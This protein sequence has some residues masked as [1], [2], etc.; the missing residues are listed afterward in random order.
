MPNT[1]EVKGE[2]FDLLNRINYMKVI[3]KADTK[4]LKIFKEVID[5][6]KEKKLQNNWK[7]LKKYV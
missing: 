1:I 4:T 3:N 7:V 2:G 6:K 5:K